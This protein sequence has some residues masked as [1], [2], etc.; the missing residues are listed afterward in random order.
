MKDEDGFLDLSGLDPAVEAAL[1]SGRKKADEARLPRR[2]RKARAKARAKQEQRKGKQ[3]LYDLDVEVKD[4]VA[5]LA[6]ELHTTASQV[7]NVLLAAGLELV[8]RGALDLRAYQSPSSS[9]R[10]DYVLRKPR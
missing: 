3:A 1:G 5:E 10:Y 9:P 7:A 4:A 6:E 8:E 2:E